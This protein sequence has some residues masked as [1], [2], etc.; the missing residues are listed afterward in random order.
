MGKTASTNIRGMKMFLEFGKDEQKENE[1]MTSGYIKDL[2]QDMLNE[3]IPP[4]LYSE[5]NLSTLQNIFQMASNQEFFKS[6]KA[7]IKAILEHWYEKIRKSEDS[8]ELKQ[9]TEKSVQ[10]TSTKR[11]RASKEE[12]R[13]GNHYTCPCCD[14]VYKRKNDCKSHMKKLHPYSC[15]LKFEP[16]YTLPTPGIQSFTTDT[17][18]QQC[19]TTAPAADIEP[20]AAD[21]ELIDMSILQTY[22]PL[23][24]QGTGAQGEILPVEEN[25]VLSLPIEDFSIFIN[26]DN[27]E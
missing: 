26:P 4:K 3:R 21:A 14:Q 20:G 23:V 24:S 11:P 27:Q 6:L 13:R 9:R 18:H 22:F 7:A 10:F 8:G 5:E 19:S 17:E 12:V 25:F 1:A 15:D 2:H 16:Q